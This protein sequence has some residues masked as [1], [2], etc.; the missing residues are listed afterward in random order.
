MQGD[1]ATP[2]RQAR[3]RAS[4][5]RGTTSNKRIAAVLAVVV[6]VLGLLTQV[7]S[8]IDWIG[9]RF[10]DEPA[11]TV[12]PAI[13]KVEPRSPSTLRDYKD[14]VNEPISG[15]SGDQLNQVG[16]VFEVTLRIQGEQG[17]RFSLKWFV[18]NEK[19]G[20]R[21]RGRSFNQ[22]PAVFEPQSASR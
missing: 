3:R 7:T 14:R 11:A 15:L 10:R 13:L 19:T 4:R 20:E 18:V 22:T 5:R 6:T 9:D 8:L 17:R 2:A 21:L 12:A 1:E 16:R